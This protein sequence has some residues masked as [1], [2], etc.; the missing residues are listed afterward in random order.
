V[1]LPQSRE[2]FEPSTTKVAILRGGLLPTYAYRFIELL[3]P[4]LQPT[5]PTKA[6][7]PHSGPK[8][9]AKNDTLQIPSFA[10]YRSRM[11]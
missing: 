8:A 11:A 7:S 5:T 4:H 1:E 3:A 10:D 9:F 6:S 2:L